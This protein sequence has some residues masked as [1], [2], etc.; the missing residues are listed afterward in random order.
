MG[1]VDPCE[2]DP[3]AMAA[4]LLAAVTPCGS[5]AARDRPAGVTHTAIDARASGGGL[6]A[7]DDALG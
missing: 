5:V 7:A 2:M 3:G 4:T 1:D 6:A